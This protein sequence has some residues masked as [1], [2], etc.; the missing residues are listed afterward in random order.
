ME[1]WLYVVDQCQ[2]SLNDNLLVGVDLHPDVLNLDLSLPLHL[3]GKVVLRPGKL[4]LL[5]LETR[6][7]LLAV[8]FYLFRGLLLGFLQ[9]LSLP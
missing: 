7:P 9:P 1:F 8:V 3:L 2:K 5:L 6:L 4:V